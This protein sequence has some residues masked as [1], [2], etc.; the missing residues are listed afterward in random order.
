MT[1][2][3]TSLGTNPPGGPFPRSTPA[4]T[5]TPYDKRARQ[6]RRH[7]RMEGLRARYPDA[8]SSCT[9]KV[10]RT[11]RDARRLARKL[12]RQGEATAAY[13]CVHCWRWHIGHKGRKR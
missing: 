5:G 2:L 6:L 12:T 4:T 13:E 7:K 8:A 1:K 3:R 11:R 9:G 10:K